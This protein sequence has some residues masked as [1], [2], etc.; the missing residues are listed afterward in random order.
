MRGLGLYSHLPG[1]LQHAA[2]SLYGLRER[3]VRLGATFSAHYARLL[4]TESASAVEI[5]AYQDEQVARLVEHAYGTVPYYRDLM[6]GYGL[7]PSD[8]RTVADLSKMPI[9]RKEDVVANW[10]ALRSTDFAQR[11]LRTGQTSGTT[12]TSLRFLT[13][14]DAVAFQWAVWWRHRAR[15][16]VV[17]GMWHVNFTIRPVVPAS[18]SG[19]PY[20]RWNIPMRQALVNTQRITPDRV[21]A[22]ARFIDAHDFRFFVGYPSTI[23]SFAELLD[24]QGTVLENGPDYVFLGAEGTQ[25]Y[26]RETIER[27]TG[28]RVSDQYGFA[29]GCGNAS[30]CEQDLYHCDWEFGVLECMDGETLPDG[31]VR[32]RILATGFANHAFP[33]IRYEVGDSAVWAPQEF[34]CACGRAS[35]VLKRIEGRNEDFV[36]TPEGTRVMRFGHLFK[37]T[38]GIK[39]AQVVQRELGAVVVVFVARPT[40]SRH[41]E[42]KVL[43]Q[44]REWVSPT[45]RV[46]FERVDE[47]PRSGSGKFRPVVSLLPRGAHEAVPQRDGLEQA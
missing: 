37:D 47:I 42:E 45:L 24:V 38:P 12:G 14:S 19:P 33:F 30:R 7:R 2:C 21:G 22:L 13:T 34:R 26:Q 23:F 31:S 5:A 46:D 41:D 40:F 10:D 15:F 35:R 43:Q 6:D 4:G 29:E 16:G 17:P 9:L 27:V 20:W 1:S 18:Q 44:I 3:Q 25:E 28:A 36:I 11:R 8:I 32:G 39:E